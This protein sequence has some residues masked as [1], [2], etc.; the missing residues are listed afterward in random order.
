[1]SWIRFSLTYIPLA[2]LAVGLWWLAEG[3]EVPE[4]FPLRVV[5]I[6]SELRSI[7]EEQVK[8][9]TSPFLVKGFFGLDVRALRDALEQLPWAQ[10]VDVRRG[11]PDR[12]LVSI[13]EQTAQAK[14]GK[15]GVLSTEGVVFYPPHDTL[16]LGLVSFSG[17]ESRAKEML[18]QYLELLERLA[19]VGLAL[20]SLELSPAGVWRA[21]LDNGI[22]LILGRTGLN[23][24]MGRFVLAYQTKLQAKSQGIA[25]V[26]LRYS[27]GVAVGWK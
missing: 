26:D 11:W 17:P 7:R 13:R 10:S 24:S 5:E 14:W 2:A 22:A 21:V 16:P 19:P 12:L 6:R 23:E 25:Y 18:T 4:R 3:I 15:N 20:Q 1:M 27:N 8:K 9:V